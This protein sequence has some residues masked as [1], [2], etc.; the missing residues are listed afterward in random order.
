MA[1]LGSPS[2]GWYTDPS[3]Q[4]RARYWDGAGWTERVRDDVAAPSAVSGGEQTHEVAATVANIAQALATVAEQDVTEP[5]FVVDYGTAEPAPVTTTEAPSTSG[6]GMVASGAVDSAPIAGWYPDPAL[7]HQAR[8]WDGFRW[9]ER[10]ADHG[11][12]GTDPVP[13]ADSVQN[14]DT[15]TGGVDPAAAAWSA[16]LLGDADLD[17]VPHVAPAEPTVSAGQ[18]SM[19][20]LTD[21]DDV[22]DER[23]R[24][25]VPVPTKVMVAGW[26]IVAGAF[27]LLLGSTMTWMTIRGPR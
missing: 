11:V 24:L 12:E 15:M 8:F 27:A 23:P 18:A 19:A 6:L 1:T 3:G 25:H 4:H 26:M 22:D 16:Q 14:A 17:G 13:G 10:V 7:R 20:M 2:A 21:R 5:V 9:T